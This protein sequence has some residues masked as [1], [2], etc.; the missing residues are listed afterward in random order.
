MDNLDDSENNAK[1]SDSAY[2][3]SCSNSQ[4]RRSHSSKSTHSGSNLS[5]SSGY[6]GQPSTTG[7]SNPPPEKRAKEKD[8]KKEKQV[9]VDTEKAKATTDC[10][11]PGPEPQLVTP[12]EE[13]QNVDQTPF[14]AL[15][16]IE[17]GPESMDIAS[18]DT[19]EG[20]EEVASCNLP[21]GNTNASVNLV[22]SRPP[23][24][25]CSEGFSCVI[26][27]HDGVVMYTTASLTTILGFPKDMWIG[28]SFIDFIHPRD[29]NTFA[30]Q[31]T[32]GLAIPKIVNGTEEKVQT[33]GNPVS[34]M[35]CR[36]R[37]YRGL[38]AGF[39]VKERTVTFMPFLLKL[40]FKNVSDEEGELTYLVIQATP[41]FS[42]FKVPNEIAVKP[43]PFVMR[44]A[45]NGNLEYIDPE[46]V[47]YLGYLPQDVVG[48][49]AIKLYHHDDLCYLRQVYETIVKEGGVPRCKPYRMMTQN[50]DYVKL[51]TEWSSFI[52]P[53]SRKL[54][55]VIGKHHLIEGPT[56]PDVFQAPDT[57]KAPKIPEEEKNK[58]QSL[59]DSI[60]KIMN[61][62]LT[63]PA[64]VA[65]QQMSKR[66]QDLAS[67]ME[68]LMEE[69]LKPSP[70]DQLQL[71][72]QDTDHSYYER[73]SMLGGISPHH[74]YNDCKS[75]TETPLSYNQLNYNEN[76]QRYFE[77]H[78]PFSCE[79]YNTVT[80]EN[81]LG[82]KDTKQLSAKCLSPMA[83]HSGDSGEMT[84]SCESGLVVRPNSP[85]A[86]LGDYQ[87]VRLTETVLNKHNSEMEKK[88]LRVHRET[89]SSSKGEREKTSNE[90]RQKK[91]EHLARCNA[92]FQ[93]AAVGTASTPG[94]VVERKSHGVKRSSKQVDSETVAHKHHCSSL[95]QSRRRHV[96]S[97]APAQPSATITTTVAAA[98]WQTNPVSNMNN[99]NTFI[100]GLGF[101]QQMQ[102]MSPAVISQ[103]VAPMQGMFPMYYAPAQPTPIPSGSEMTNPDPTK[104]ANANAQFPAPAMQCMMYGQA[105]YGSPFMY[106][107][108]APQMSQMTY[109]AMQ[110]SMMH[111][112]T[113]FN[114]S[115]NPLG[116]TSSNYE[117]ACKPSV[118]L[119]LTKS[120]GGWR[121]LKRD[122]PQAASSKT[123][124][125][126]ADSSSST[127]ALNRST[128]AVPDTAACRNLT[129]KSA[130]MRNSDGT[131]DRTDGDSSSS[132]FYSSFFKTESGSAED[133]GDKLGAKLRTTTANFWTK[134]TPDDQSSLG[135]TKA[136]RESKH[137]KITRRKMEPPWMEQVCVSSEL[138]YKYQVLTKTLEE[139]LTSDKQKMINLA[140]PSL[141]NEQL[142]QLYLDLQLEGV[143]ARL[144]LEEG[145]TSSSSSGEET[146]T[147]SKKTTKRKREYSKLVMIYEEDAPLPPPADDDMTPS[148]TT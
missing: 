68:S 104:N 65:K 24:L 41:F 5:G 142:G 85:V 80:G 126:S 90:K 72:I 98:H 76:M 83:Q 66:C 146:T 31:I 97:A 94:P 34:T 73:D 26:S 133:S 44:H 50:G 49:D 122:D 19:S 120:G 20:K 21:I 27:M 137:K 116:L 38:S 107:P 46:S 69:P 55:F 22:A 48:E 56:N 36:I 110:Q 37:R 121:D 88:L 147:N 59:R 29:R 81:I 32:S 42:A 51:E 91:K 4:S 109:P 52:N 71:E 95:R 106:S 10:C 12:K 75:S 30:S 93:P 77:S 119:R 138:I 35:V 82:L 112:T 101:P 132:S 28:R 17:K 114:N 54:E 23:K 100:L 11:P 89:R 15:S 1:I 118:P 127:N 58:H 57:E 84:S 102:I 64:E 53:W 3:N 128:E 135:A 134:S 39:G 67:F 13:E 108:I 45:A 115:L 63:K 148:T 16:H 140:Q 9:Q 8:T 2:S 105:M 99:M 78:Q 7:S 86:F 87:R 124:L 143:A 96:T 139:V 141:V 40:A 47:P 61:E 6:G 33:P 25:Y 92:S 145:I 43:I 144:T 129:A 60:V 130:R 14:P 117:E 123:D 79:D 70:N 125:G 103:Q 62:V 111:Q 113:Q 131:V 74:D 18:P 136:Y